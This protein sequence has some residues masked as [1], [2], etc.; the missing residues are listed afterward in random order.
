[1]GPERKELEALLAERRR[2]LQ[3]MEDLAARSAELARQH[4]DL[5][6]QHA[7]LVEELKRMTRGRA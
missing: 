5:A 3:E 6:K 7:E 1:M 4:A 2:R